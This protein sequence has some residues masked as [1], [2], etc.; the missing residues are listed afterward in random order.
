[1]G[2]EKGLPVLM[3]SENKGQRGERRTG[4]KQLEVSV[5]GHSGCEVRE[6]GLM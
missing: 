6:M 5:G 3:L 2:G 4:L 1:M